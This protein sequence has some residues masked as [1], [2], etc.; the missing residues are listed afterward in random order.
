MKITNGSK[1]Y[2]TDQWSE[3]KVNNY[4]NSGWTK[5][6]ESK[7]SPSKKKDN[8]HKVETV[9]ELVSHKPTNLEEN[10]NGGN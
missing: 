4:L 2:D 10:D 9:E 7:K 5:D 8:K 1:T 3:D 6:G